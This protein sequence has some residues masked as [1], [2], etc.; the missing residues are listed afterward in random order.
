L[1]TYI[2]YLRKL[3]SAQQCVVNGLKHLGLIELYSR[4]ITDAVMSDI[5]VT[6]ANNIS[7]ANIEKLEFLDILVQLLG[8]YTTFINT[9]AQDPSTTGFIDKVQML[10]FIKRKL[11]YLH[12][13]E[14]A[15]SIRDE[16]EDGREDSES[17]KMT[18]DLA[19][20]DAIIKN[21]PKDVRG[22]IN[23]NI[24]KINR[25]LRPKLS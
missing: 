22:E 14:D 2:R 1:R 8:N 9:L 15:I 11:A 24:S 4:G 25:E 21:L 3:D 18:E 13:A 5:Q 7:L 6:F 23:N 17:K 12:G 16:E 10:S 20:I 19:D